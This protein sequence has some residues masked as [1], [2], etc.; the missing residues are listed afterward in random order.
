M[1]TK[2]AHPSPIPLLQTNYSSQ[3]HINR[4]I[5]LVYHYLSLINYTFPV[6]TC[7]LEITLVPSLLSPYNMHFSCHYLSQRYYTCPRWITLVPDGLHLPHIDYTC[8]PDHPS[9]GHPVAVVAMFAPFPCTYT[10]VV[11]L[12]IRPRRQSPRQR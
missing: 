5:A 4:C 9:S 12:L 10:C 11:L 6:I 2:A 1:Q 7:P 3:K 8:L